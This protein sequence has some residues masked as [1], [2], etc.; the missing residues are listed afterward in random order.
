MIWDFGDGS[1][2]DTGLYVNH[3]YTRN[4]LYRVTAYLVGECGIAA[5]LKS[6]QETLDVFDATSITGV[7]GMDVKLYPNPAQDVLTIEVSGTSVQDV[8]VYTILGQK[9]L[10]ESIR[11]GTSVRLNTSALPSGMYQ[12]MIIT[13]KGNVI[14]KVEILK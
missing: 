11:P 1:P 9:V 5:E 2:R 6:Y 3:K 14:R 12:V 4:G 7:E 10:T 8:A 13:D